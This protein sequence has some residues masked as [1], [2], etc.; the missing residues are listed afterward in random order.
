MSEEYEKEQKALKARLSELDGPLAEGKKREKDIRIFADIVESCTN[1]EKISSELLHIL[2]D[3]IVVHEKEVAENE[4]IMRVEI[5]YRLIGNVGDEA[6]DKLKAPKIRH[7]RWSK[8]PELV[9][10]D[11]PE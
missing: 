5:Y 2:V 4:I 3:R 8:K 10:D 9:Y 7:Q 11:V 6:G 1:V